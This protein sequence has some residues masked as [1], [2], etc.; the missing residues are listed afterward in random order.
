MPKL[1]VTGGHATPAI[2]VI[3]ALQKDGTWEFDWIGEKQAI[4]G[5]RTKTLESQVL[6]N[7][8][9]PFHP[10]TFPKLH[11]DNI[12]K[13]LFFL[14]KTPVGFL[15]SFYAL[16]KLR[17]NVVLTFGS[18]LSFPVAL[19]AAFLGIPIVVHEQTAASGLA[20]R[21]VGLLARRVAISFETSSNYF[22]K[23]KAVL[24]GN[25]IRQAFFEVAKRRS[26]KKPAKTPCVL[27]FGGSRGSVAINNAVL[28]S[29]HAILLK[30]DLLHVTGELDYERVLKV[31]DSLLPKLKTRYSVHKTL[32]FSEVEK[33]LE[34]SD[35]AISRAGANTVTEFAAVGLPAIFIPLPIADSDEQTKNAKVLVKAGSALLL[36]QQELSKKRLLEN[37]DKMLVN[38]PEFRRKGLETRTLVKKDAA[39]RIAKLVKGCV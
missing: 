32:S 6:P 3:E 10:I 26:R 14:W 28:D 39:E 12:F 38:L 7:L 22:Q 17:P 19:S 18:Y 2:A 33:A 8:G 9:V 36:P 5:K 30:C 23:E 37:L 31:R 16:S 13:T 21:I 34:K 11:R 35:F 24:T 27:V 20:N 29:L 15:Q 4:E 1:V 25:P